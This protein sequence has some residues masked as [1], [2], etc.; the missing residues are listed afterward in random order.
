MVLSILLN[1]LFGVLFV[2]LFT[3]IIIKYLFYVSNNLD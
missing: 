3:F 2:T 1:V